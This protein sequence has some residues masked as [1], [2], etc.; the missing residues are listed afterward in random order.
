[1]AE[2]SGDRR[3]SEIFRQYGHCKDR[4]ILPDSHMNQ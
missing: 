2:L 1:M 4:R 3:L